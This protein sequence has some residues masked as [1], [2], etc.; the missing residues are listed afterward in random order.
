MYTYKIGE[1]KSWNKFFKNIEQMG[2]YSVRYG[3]FVAESI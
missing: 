3:G 1:V 2:Y